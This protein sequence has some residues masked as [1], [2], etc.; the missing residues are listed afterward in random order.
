MIM[1]ATDTG[2]M[3]GELGENFKEIQEMKP[4]VMLNII[5]GWVPD[6]TSI[7]IRLLLAVLIFLIGR[8]IIKLL[9]KMVDRSF[10]RSS[11]EVSVAKFLHSLIGFSLNA[12]LLFVILGQLGFNAASIVAILGSA[13]LALGLALQGSLANFAGSILI[14]MMKPFKVGDYIVTQQCEGTV[15]MI[16]LVYTTLLTIDNRSVTIPNGTLSNTTVTNVTAMDMRRLDLKVGIGYSSDLKKAKAVLEHIYQTH[17]L[18]KKDEAISVY[19]DELASSTVTL[20]ARG[21]TSAADYWTARWDIL[22]QIKLKFD[23]AGIEIPFKQ[24]DVHLKKE[25]V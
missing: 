9:Q 7:G 21:W 6:L 16:G 25:N 4:N 1:L 8:K 19:V 12:V 15:A 14:L 5:K 22:E 17:P 10:K 20:G 18:I 13:G 24:M 23:E 11:M 3:L 2:T